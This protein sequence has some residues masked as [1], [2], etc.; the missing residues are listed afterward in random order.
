MTLASPL[1]LSRDPL[2]QRSLLIHSNL[3][4]FAVELS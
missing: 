2:A 1:S 4:T 3:S